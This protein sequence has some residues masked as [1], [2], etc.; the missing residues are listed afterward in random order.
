[1]D[2]LSSGLAEFVKKNITVVTT[3]KDEGRT[4]VFEGKVIKVGQDYLLIE[5]SDNNR[6]FIN[7]AYV[8]RFFENA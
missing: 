7:L 2:T 6:Q 1:M 5:T 3:E 4:V 8:I